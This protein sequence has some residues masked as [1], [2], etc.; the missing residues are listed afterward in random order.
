[1]LSVHSLCIGALLAGSV[2]SQVNPFV[3]YPQDPER[4]TLTCT[5]F[6]GRPDLAA[7]GEALMEIRSDDF[8]GIGLVTAVA[9]GQV[10]IM[11]LFGVF[12]WLADERLTTI[13]TYDLVMRNGAA[14]GGPDMSPAGQFLRIAGLTSPPSTNPQRGTWIMYDGFNILGGFVIT[15]QNQQTMAPDRLYVGIGMAANPLWPTTDGHSLFRADMLNAG[16]GATVGENHRLGAPPPTW[17][18]KIG[19][20]SFSTP[21]SYVLGPLVTSPNLHI[22]GLDPT[23]LRLGAPGANL[24]MN[25]LY[26][27]IS[28]T[29]RRDGLIVRVT[30]TITPF[31]LVALGGSLGF[32]PGDFNFQLFSSLNVIGYSFV[33]DAT[34]PPLLLTFGALSLGEREWTM[35][36]PNTLSPSLQGMDVAF[37]AIVFDTNG[38]QFSEWTNAQEVHL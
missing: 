37:Q 10:P 17:A 1:M 2:L 26:P 9:G 6:V 5:S 31:G 24:S 12:H 21:W 20:P 11:R 23:S 14:T 7:A 34:N 38:P 13:E 25:G 18:G 8:R 19:S 33:G 36:L 28:A 29:P 32:R 30:D 3:F 15:P 16:T 4:Q 35:A 27:D 22:G